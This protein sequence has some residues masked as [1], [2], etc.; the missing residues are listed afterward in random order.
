MTNEEKRAVLEA[1]GYT[2]TITDPNRC[3]DPYVYISPCRKVETG[4]AL[5]RVIRAA[6]EH[7]ERNKHET[8]R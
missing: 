4:K 5:N 6:W 1:V 3:S 2:F 8:T 7:Y